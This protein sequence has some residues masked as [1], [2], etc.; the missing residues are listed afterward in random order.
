MSGMHGLDV[1]IEKIERKTTQSEINKI[2]ELEL[3]KISKKFKRETLPIYDKKKDILKLV[4]IQQVFPKHQV[5]FPIDKSKAETADMI[6]R[7]TRDLL[8]GDASETAIA[9][10]SIEKLLNSEQRE[11]IFPFFGAIFE[12]QIQEKAFPL[13]KL[14]QNI[15]AENEK[16]VSKYFEDIRRLSKYAKNSEA[17]R[18][19]IILLTRFC[20]KENVLSTQDIKAYVGLVENTPSFVFEAYMA[21]FDCLSKQGLLGNAEIERLHGICL[22]TLKACAMRSEN[23]NTLSLIVSI[24]HFLRSTE[25]LPEKI[26]LELLFVLEKV[27]SVQ[28]GGKTHD[29]RRKAVAEISLLEVLAGQKAIFQRA[30]FVVSDLL[31][32]T[33]SES[34]V[35]KAAILRLVAFLVGKNNTVCSLLSE[36]KSG[37]FI[38]LLFSKMPFIRKCARQ[39]MERLTFNDKEA[40][41]S[42]YGTICRKL[43]NRQGHAR[44]AIFDQKYKGNPYFFQGAVRI[45]CLICQ[46][47]IPES[48]W[49]FEKSVALLCLFNGA[50][51]EDEFIQRLALGIEV[52]PNREAHIGLFV[53]V[54][55]REVRRNPLFIG[56]VCFLLCRYKT[57]AK[58][59][60][61]QL[62]FL[63]FFFKRKNSPKT[64][65]SLLMAIFS[66]SEAER[67]LTAPV[68]SLL[69]SHECSDEKCGE[70][71]ALFSVANQERILEEK[72]RIS[73]VPYN[74]FHNRGEDA[75]FPELSSFSDFHLLACTTSKNDISVSSLLCTSGVLYEDTRIQV[76]FLFFYPPERKSVAKITLYVGNRAGVDLTNCYLRHVCGPSDKKLLIESNGHFPQEIKAGTQGKITLDLAYLSPFHRIPLMGFICQEV[77]EVDFFLPVSLLRFC[78]ITA[79]DGEKPSFSLS[80]SIQTPDFIEKDRVV[81]FLDFFMQRRSEDVWVSI[82]GEKTHIKLCISF[83]RAEI[84]FTC[85]A[86]TQDAANCFLETVVSVLSKF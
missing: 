38:E 41:Q 73:L 36:K 60:Y 44:E 51:C 2:I 43:G 78:S 18:E 84:A 30:L 11:R 79:T 56:L 24:C 63:S 9:C 74:W 59:P 57:R 69:S 83:Q 12:A 85:F 31:K 26:V 21:F 40:A 15:F 75:A 32:E 61:D 67:A 86:D 71:Y 13:L 6:V 42:I 34:A 52:S 7:I 39:I 72:T 3:A 68:L 19:A 27:A 16:A 82:L 4:F 66:L 48:A 81:C 46:R 35:M 22:S 1:F 29:E 70:Y 54:N 10:L 47:N 33:E 50:C 80:R 45:L 37:R 25:D 23:K 62:C 8:L 14:F 77:E 53:S 20:Q 28:Q 58:S 49:A 76:G 65:T 64:H 17:R 5:A 55:P